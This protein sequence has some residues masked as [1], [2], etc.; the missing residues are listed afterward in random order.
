MMHASVLR[1][2]REVAERGSIRKAAD[3]LYIASSAVNRQILKLEDEI[4]VPLFER[5]PT[6][7]R[8]TS[9]G[10]LLLRHVRDTLNEF[11][12]VRSEIDDL[13]GLKT[14][15]VRVASLI[16]L[17][18]EFLPRMMVDFHRRYPGL[19][20]QL[21]SYGPEQIIEELAAGRA[22][23]GLNFTDVGS[24]GFTQL[25]DAPAPQGALVVADHPLAGR[26]RVSLVDCANYPLLLWSEAGP[27]APYLR[28]A[29]KANEI[30][31]TPR[32]LCNSLDAIK[33]LLRADMGVA[34]FSR[35]GFESDIAAGE[36]V[37]VPFSEPF[38]ADRR[39]GVFIPAN[40]KLAIGAAMFAEH[41]RTGF[42]TMAKTGRPT[43]GSR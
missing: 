7:V 29:L 15:L 38:L 30:V 40:R 24:G 2:F 25:A 35:F 11:D 34:L 42:E 9:A 21:N 32:A 1:Y 17:M 18:A 8:L 19:N 41:L 33:H 28:S 27:L 36:I 20:F 43:H 22:D 26:D 31:A 39:V 23:I 4:G 5:L 6:G 16:G 37:H 10:E 3:A 14:G 13:R 12:R